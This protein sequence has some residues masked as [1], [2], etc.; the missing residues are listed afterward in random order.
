MTKSSRLRIVPN[1]SHSIVEENA[2][3]VAG[4]LLRFVDELPP[5]K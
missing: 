2:D 1:G 3:A 4:E 5:W